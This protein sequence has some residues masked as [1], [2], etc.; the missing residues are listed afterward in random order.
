[1]STFLDLTEYVYAK[2]GHKV[3]PATVSTP[4]RHGPDFHRP[5]SQI[6]IESPDHARW[7]VDEVFRQAEIIQNFIAFL[8]KC[9]YQSYQQF[10]PLH[11]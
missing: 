8:Q 9:L 4:S 6:T 2:I 10:A 5:Q 11:P 3:C 7:V 1:M